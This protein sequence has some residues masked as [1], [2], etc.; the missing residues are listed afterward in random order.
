MSAI[1]FPYRRLVYA[2]VMLG[3]AAFSIAQSSPAALLLLGALAIGSWYLVEGPSGRPL[4]R[5]VTNL[6]ALAAIAWLMMDL[7]IRGTPGLVAIGHF[8]IWLQLLL[9]YGR[10]G[11]R[12]DAM[13]LV[14]SLLLMVDASLL[15]FSMVYGVLL[16]AYSLL[17]VWT[18]AAFNFSATADH[19]VR[20]AREATGDG[21]A[22][23]GVAG[24]PTMRRDVL[25]GGVLLSLGAFGLAVVVFI[26]APRVEGLGDAAASRVLSGV[27]SI[28][29]NSEVQLGQRIGE[30]DSQEPV[31]MVTMRDAD[32]QNVGSNN[33]VWY[34]R[35]GCADRYDA[36]LRTWSRGGEVD[37]WDVEIQMRGE[38]ASVMLAAA[39][40]RRP[41]I[42]AE[43][44]VRQPRQARLFSPFPPL[45]VESDA[46]T[47][48]SFGTI[49]QQLLARP[50]G[51]RTVSYRVRHAYPV[52]ADSA[53][54]D[55][56]AR[57]AHHYPRPGA[58]IAAARNLP[59]FDPRTY[60]RG[61]P[62][63]T[64]EVR[65]MA[66]SMLDE[67]KLSR[68]ETV[69]HDPLD[70]T[71]AEALTAS[72]RRNFIYQLSAA[73]HEGESDPVIHFLFNS[74]EGHCELF[75]AG[76]AALARSI[77]MR[78]RLATG[79]LA[80][81]FNTVGGY[82][83]VRPANAHAWCEIE[84]APG[85]WQRFDPT[86]PAQRDLQHHVEA[87]WT[88]RLRQFYEHLDFVWIRSVVAYDPKT[89]QAML[90]ATY[91]LLARSAAVRDEA[92]DH[93]ERLK[94]RLTDGASPLSLALGG[95][96][97]AA[98]AAALGTSMVW[99]WRGR[100]GRRSGA[101]SSA[102]VDGRRARRR[103]VA[104]YTSMMHLLERH[105][106]IR[107]PWQGPRQ[108]IAQLAARQPRRFAPAVDLTEL[109]Y[110]VHF[111]GH[112]LDGPRREQ[113]HTLLVELR[114]RLEAKDIALRADR[115]SPRRPGY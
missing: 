106:H 83:I 23:L 70:A 59:R 11:Y 37:Q 72:L 48:V 99:M 93:L 102:G 41:S 62:V 84:V 58:Q 90:H 38:P 82:Y 12:D 34:L 65:A 81:E 113:A 88:R 114:Q 1:F 33:R 64:D 26:F 115:A 36:R 97:I 42:E 4:P 9:L 60:A 87:T 57:L 2:Q 24:G 63:R 49:D 27:A 25:R 96:L 56:Y 77:G 40:G 6:G 15:S 79:Y 8:M 68:D 61:W 74:R 66:L 76:L 111:G 92:A 44:T 29:F 50:R 19:V 51:N 75:A 35:G 91:R 95:L 46:M 31:M 52:A 78:A 89:R 80:S 101:A 3:L 22:E 45:E 110:A 17:T 112:A 107:P 100:R 71:I 69:D 28:G 13:A 55:G 47:R 20:R 86:P 105:G 14:L 7:Q 54:F 18:L 73:G 108:F 16:A 39:S 21:A 32:G 98:F 5:S 30:P 67:A 53:I 94:R 10:Q 103:A 85:V 104:F 109:F 43:I